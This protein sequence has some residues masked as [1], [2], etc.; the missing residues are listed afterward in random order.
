MI[1][2]NINATLWFEKDFNLL[3]LHIGEPKEF[4]KRKD[5]ALQ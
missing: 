1:K 3:G 4:Y 5:N 2:N